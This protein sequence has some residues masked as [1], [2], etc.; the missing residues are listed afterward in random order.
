[1][2]RLKACS[3]GD[4]RVYSLKGTELKIGRGGEN[5]IIL[6]DF[7]VSRRHAELRKEG[8]QWFIHDLRSTNG[9]QLNRLTVRKA[10]IHPGDRIKIGIFEF[11]VE[12]ELP[13][14]APRPLVSVQP[15][16]GES[17]MSSATI[18][19]RIADFSADYGLESKTSAI[20]EKD[21]ETA[22][23]K[24]PESSSD[25]GIRSIKREELEKAYA[26]RIF[27]FLTRL[28]SLLSKG[29]SVDEI[30]EKV[31]DIA[32]DAL[33]V[34]RGFILLTDE[35]SGET[36]C[37]LAREGSKSEYR[38]KGAVPVSDTMV[39]TVMTERVALLT[40]DAQ[41]DQR[42][43]TGDSIR[44]HQIRAAMCSPLWSGERIIGVMQVDSPFHVGTFNENDLDL[45]TALANFAAVAVERIRNAEQVEKERQ[46]RS[47]LER[48]HSPAVIDL[49]M[50]EGAASAEG[51]IRRLKA[52]DVTV[53]FAD[54]VGFTSLSESSSP[55]DVA[56]VLRGYF[57]QC[58]EAIFAQ[59][60]TLDKFIGDC[61]MAFFGA[62][63]A[64]E[65]HAAR[66]V[67]SAIEM[68]RRILYWNKQQPDSPLQCRIAINSGPVV[69]GDVGS[70]KRVDYTVL[71]NTVNIA[72]RLESTVAEPGEIVVGESTYEL[73]EGTLIAE[74][75]GDRELKGL[76]Q[77]IH[78][79]RIP[80]R[81]TLE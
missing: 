23:R 32:F 79:W 2:W 28:G 34:D 20:T 49:V 54:V 58:V 15:A 65:D 59:G 75:L 57:N 78:A 71:G 37:Q 33:P 1:M 52:A 30:L 38:P 66:A 9:I 69:V 14:V 29:D 48:Y 25:S 70:D 50:N 27:G 19:R 68:Q 43:V 77:K 76:Q 62:P 73:L 3:G 51:E 72:A 11:D 39:E 24:P 45:F 5:H 18:I 61:V 21:L 67:R 31:M 22:G 8:E 26:N 35:G 47:R 46:M 64:Q 81:E 7:S 12:G 41:T 55:R 60:G 74:P 10:P 13:K 36:V 42:L 40:Y 56:K 80:W 6:S 17:S 63:M 16:P 4:E 44:I 53:L